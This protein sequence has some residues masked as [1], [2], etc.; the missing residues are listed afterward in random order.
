MRITLK[1]SYRMNISYFKELR[2]YRPQTISATDE[3]S[4]PPHRPQPTPYRPQ[5]EFVHTPLVTCV[6]PLSPVHTVA[7]K[8]DC[9]RIRRQS[10]FS[11][12]VW[13]GL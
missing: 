7:E 1:E 3:I 2:R 12:T 5:A 13:T 6:A 10:H 8:S 9:R 4:H 11:A